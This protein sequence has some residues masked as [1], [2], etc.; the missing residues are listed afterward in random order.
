MDIKIRRINHVGVI[1]RELTAAK[2]FF[3][4]LGLEVLGEAE[5]EGEW[6]EQKIGLTDFRKTVVMLGMPDGETTLELVKFHTLSDEKGFQQYFS[7]NLGVCHIAFDVENIEVIVTKLKKRGAE[8]F[9]EIQNYENVYKLCY[10]RG[11]EGIVLEL[12]EKIN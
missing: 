2:E 11:P 8:L 6:I 7:T 3:L 10:V 9:G 4:D 1:V 5:V 12:A